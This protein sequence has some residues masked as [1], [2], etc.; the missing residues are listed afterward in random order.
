VLFLK[1]FRRTEEEE[2]RDE[3]DEQIWRE[4]GA[5]GWITVEFSKPGGHS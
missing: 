2:K 5:R 4:K 1:R 3:G